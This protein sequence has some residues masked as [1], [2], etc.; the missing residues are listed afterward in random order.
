MKENEPKNKKKIIYDSRSAKQP[1]AQA[2]YVFMMFMVDYYARVKEELGLDYDS[3]MI[4]QTV[5]SHSVYHIKK[6]VD[7]NSYQELESN[8][9]QIFEKNKLI[10]L[11]FNEKVKSKKINKFKLTISSISLVTKLPKETVRRKILELTDKNILKISYKNGVTVGLNY[12]K[13]FSEFVPTT[14][15]EVGKLVKNWK[16]TGAL[17]VLLSMKS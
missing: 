2:M 12:K 11:E 7:I 14:T 13:I 6:K 8:L 5:A 3:F 16:K 9:D 4:I 1:F 10:D 15:F 17:E